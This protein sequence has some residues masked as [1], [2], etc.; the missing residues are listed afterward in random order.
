MYLI[1]AMVNGYYVNI[2]TFLTKH[3]S[4]VTNSIMGDIVTGGLITPIV[5]HV[6]V[7]FY[8]DI[9]LP[10]MGH[11]CCDLGSLLNMR[12]IY[13]DGESYGIMVHERAGLYLLNR[14]QE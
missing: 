1:H 3:L 7:A 9:E 4:R 6:D 14:K 12:M 10:I 13:P 5:E 8:E 11:S 2:P